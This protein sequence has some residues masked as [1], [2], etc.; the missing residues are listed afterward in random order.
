M[1]S[2]HT[3][4]QLDIF[5]GFAAILMVLNHAGFEW[6]SVAGATTGFDGVVVFLGSAAPALFF[7][8]TGVGMGLSQR[9]GI[10]WPGVLRKVVLLLIADL[11][12]GWG[13]NRWLGLDFFAF[14][15]IS[16]LAVSL[17]AGARHP[18]RV[19]TAAIAAC[20]LARYAFVPLLQ[21]L[22]GDFPVV[23]FATGIEGVANISYPLSPWL[24]FP[25]AG[26]ILGRLSAPADAVTPPAPS[27][28]VVAALAAMSGGLA[29]WLGSRGAV[30]HRWNTVSVGYFLFA[31]AF[32][33]AVWLTSDVVA[34]AVKS[35]IAA[36][37]QTRG[38]ASLLIVPVHYALIGIVA[39]VLS[40]PWH[41][42]TWFP[43][44]LVLCAVVLASSKWIAT[45]LRRWAVHPRASRG[46]ALSLP[47]CA[48]VTAF[49]VILAPPLVRLLVA[50]LGQVLVAANL[51]R[52][53]QAVLRPDRRRTL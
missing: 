11:F 44:A 31:F 48:A 45:C 37:L 24:V 32:V 36:A 4:R 8:A 14:C 28:I 43:A 53:E 3:S 26:F 6:L 21:P 12:L 40:P 47:A 18:I 29:W 19:A 33:G 1:S 23:A 9:N 51:A 20:L 10:D 30:M 35:R 38:P 50:C 2:S 39:A 13:A 46:L 17:A 52:P 34:L 41:A 22:A 49:C 25:L 5:R 15:A 7:T 42:E 27:R 16:M